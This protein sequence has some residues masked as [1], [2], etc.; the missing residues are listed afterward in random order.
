MG[1]VGNEG[2]RWDGHRQGEV[3]RAENTH[4]QQVGGGGGQAGGRRRGR[5][6]WQTGR[7]GWQG[8]HPTAN[9]TLSHPLVP[10]SSESG[11]ARILNSANLEAR[12]ETPARA[13]VSSQSAEQY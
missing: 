1:R 8:W 4:K 3:I 5:G 11:D 7:G 13:S 10:A 6:G 12:A 2:R 9:V